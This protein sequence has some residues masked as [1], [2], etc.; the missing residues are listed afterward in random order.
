MQRI[1][2][3]NDVR[4]NL[5]LRGPRSYDAANI[6]EMR[7]YLINTSIANFMPDL[8][9]DSCCGDHRCG[10]PKYHVQPCMVPHKDPR[11]DDCCGH[12]C[13]LHRSA[14]PAAGQGC[15]PPNYGECGSWGPYDPCCHNLCEDK[16]MQ[17]NAGYCCMYDH[18]HHYDVF[19]KDTR[20]P[21]LNPDAKY[22]AYSKILNK[23]NGVQVYF[24]ARDQFM[25]GIYKL[26]IALVVYEPGWGRCDLHTYTIDYGDVI[27]LVCDN[28][29]ASGDI[30]VDVDTDTM[31]NTNITDINIKF[32]SLYLYSNSSLDLGESDVRNHAY[33]IEVTLENG[34]T[35]EYTP[36]NWPYESLV[37]SSSRTQ[38]VSVNNKTGKLTAVSTDD[39]AQAMITVES[40]NNEVS[41]TF[42]VNVIG[43]GYDYVGFL[44][45]RPFAEADEDDALNHFNRHDQGFENDSQ[46]YY[47][48]AGAQ[49]VTLS[50]LTKV[51]DITKPVD[52][53]NDK[54][55][56]YLWIVTRNPI[57]NAQAANTTGA[58][59]SFA[60][61]IPLTK[62]QQVAENDLYYYACPNPMQATDGD[63]LSVW[64]KLKE[65]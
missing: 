24:P 40:K 32:N 50:K 43:G 1:R 3:G 58:G 51:L 49:A 30:T 35:L 10:H 41:A 6:K 38:V 19:D 39:S 59:M 45:V 36:E 18:H 57:L 62:V 11:R 15:L 28:T 9:C 46:E 22:L 29:G 54:D 14:N 65:D 56:Q 63:P 34:S 13:M 20:V 53:E 44:P 33:I 61:Y 17:W 42:Q 16:F 8:P 60:T 23:K 21:F 52:V 27:Q 4:L 5:T 12:N 47:T 48:A 25:C 26:V 2:I 31:A 7:C 55:G 64:A 37:F